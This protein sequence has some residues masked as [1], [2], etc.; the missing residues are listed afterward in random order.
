[1]TP[2]VLPHASSVYA[3]YTLRVDVRDELSKALNALGVPTAVHYP[4]PL[5]LQPAFGYLGLKEGAFPVAEACSQSVLS[6][7]MGPDVTEEQQI[8]V[9][10]SLQK[11]LQGFA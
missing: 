2:C 9:V 5:H 8:F 7:P 4:I 11:T 10:D 1:M 6:L 3:Q